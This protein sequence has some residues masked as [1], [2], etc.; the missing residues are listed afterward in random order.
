MLPVIWKTNSNSSV[1]EIIFQNWFSLHF[2]A[3]VGKYS[4]DIIYQSDL[5]L[6]NAPG[7]PQS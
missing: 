2:V 5:I 3:A 4:A 1:N 6:D 7:H